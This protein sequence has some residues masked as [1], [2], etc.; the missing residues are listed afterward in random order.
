MYAAL[1]AAMKMTIIGHLPFQC[2]ILCLK[3]GIYNIKYLIHLEHLVE[4]HWG[5]FVI[6]ASKCSITVFS[7]MQRR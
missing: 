5:Y 7:K 6:D 1:I 2:S 4:E 3:A